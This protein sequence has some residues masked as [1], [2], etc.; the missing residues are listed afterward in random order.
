MVVFGATATA[1]S[2]SVASP[3][4]AW[5]HGCMVGLKGTWMHGCM[6]AWMH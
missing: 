6:D 1:T 4:G 2:T 5:M 3:V